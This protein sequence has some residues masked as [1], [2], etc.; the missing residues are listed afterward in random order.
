MKKRKELGWSTSGA[1]PHRR[2]SAFGKDTS[3]PRHESASDIK[4][5]K[6]CILPSLEADSRRNLA[7]LRQIENPAD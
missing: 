4:C 3:R 7:R 6:G 1:P 2:V 5:H